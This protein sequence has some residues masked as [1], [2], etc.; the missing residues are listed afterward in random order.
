MGNGRA[1]AVAGLILLAGAGTAR[2]C[3]EGAVLVEGDF[4]RARFA[5]EVADDPEERA[6]GLMF[7]ERMPLMA[8]MLFVYEEPQHARFWM[9]NTLI[10]LDMLFADA[11]GTVTRLHSEAVPMDTTAI[12]GGEDVQFVLEIN[13][14]LAER[15]GIAA[16]D[17][18]VHPA[19]GCD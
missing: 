4:G 16:G 15:L 6:R 12:D 10:P 2:A 13:G 5:V 19:I 7:V 8:G 9:Q 17:R 11:E 3:E 18:L 14:G 1:G